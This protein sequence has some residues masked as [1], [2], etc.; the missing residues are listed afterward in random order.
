MKKKNKQTMTYAPILNMN[1]YNSNNTKFITSKGFK[2]K[3]K[4][5]KEIVNKNISY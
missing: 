5:V 1:S 2:S 4:N 3:V